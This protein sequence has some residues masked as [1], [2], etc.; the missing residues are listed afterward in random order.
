MFKK[1]VEAKSQQRLSGADRKK[2][3]RTVKEKFPR[4]SDSDLDTLLPPKVSSILFYS[5]HI[6]SNNIQ[7]SILYIILLM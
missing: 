7:I 3:K 6:H 4:A 2:L 1:A 5:F